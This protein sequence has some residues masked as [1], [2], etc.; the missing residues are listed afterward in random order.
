MHID[1]L[2]YEN[3]PHMEAD[4]AAPSSTKLG[5]HSQAAR[6]RYSLRTL[7]QRSNVKLSGA[8]NCGLTK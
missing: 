3:M 2:H 5:D 4:V 8:A 6:V 1:S 7:S